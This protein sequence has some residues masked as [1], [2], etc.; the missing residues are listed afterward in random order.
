MRRLR[1]DAWGRAMKIVL[2]GMLSIAA[3]AGSLL[4]GE[5]R[6]SPEG[7]SPRTAI[8]QIRAARER[9]DSSRWTVRI[10]PGE[11]RL[12]EPLT[13]LSGDGNI[14]FHGDAGAILTGGGEI[15]PWTDDG[16]GVWSAPIPVGADGKPVWFESLFVNG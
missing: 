9:G 5:L 11:Y 16:D 14:A 4:A 7:L 3:V 2:S 6:V 8:D 12:T 1:T 13:L 10:S 15:G